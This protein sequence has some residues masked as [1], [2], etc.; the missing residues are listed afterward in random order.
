VNE[1]RLEFRA[2]NDLSIALAHA[3]DAVAA[4]E[5]NLQAEAVLAAIAEELR[6]GHLVDTPLVDYYDLLRERYLNPPRFRIDG[7]PWLFDQLALA[8]DMRDESGE[9]R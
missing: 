6:Q 9:G 2:L 4:R 8:P 3:G 5:A 7:F 1:P